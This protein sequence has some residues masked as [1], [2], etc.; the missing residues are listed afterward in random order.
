MAK[1]ELGSLPLAGLVAGLQGKPA[2]RKKEA[3]KT[4]AFRSILK[5]A[6]SAEATPAA[7]GEPYSEAAVAELLDGVHESGDALK[8]DQ[9]AENV[10]AYKKA[11]RDFVHYVVERAYT[12]EERTSGRNILKR[13]KFTSVA[14]ID[15]KLERLAAEVMSAQRDRL[16]ILRRMDEIHGLLVDLMQ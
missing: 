13:K 7:L 1:V 3:R 8:R 16:D 12:L 14:V 15:E 11:V 5:E 4:E 9:N 6:E 2:E 10:K